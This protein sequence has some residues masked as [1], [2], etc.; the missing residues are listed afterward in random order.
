MICY[1]IVFKMIHIYNLKYIHIMLFIACAVSIHR[2]RYIYIRQGNIFMYKR[3]TSKT[4]LAI[5]VH[6]SD[7]LLGKIAC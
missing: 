2:G 4:I 6:L 7:L 1:K 3:Y 5:A